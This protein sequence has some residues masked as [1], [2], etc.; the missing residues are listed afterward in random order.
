[1]EVLNNTQQQHLL[2]NSPQSIMRTKFGISFHSWGIVEGHHFTPKKLMSNSREQ[3]SGLQGWSHCTLPVLVRL[4]SVPDQ[5]QWAPLW[6][7]NFRLGDSQR[8]WG[9]S[10]NEAHEGS[11]CAGPDQPN[12]K[13][14]FF[15]S[16]MSPLRCSLECSMLGKLDRFHLTDVFFDIMQNDTG[17]IVNVSA[18]GCPHCRVLSEKDSPELKRLQFLL[19]HFA[20]YQEIHPWDENGQVLLTWT[21]VFC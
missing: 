8:T 4:G 20:L 12:T 10:R 18:L 11:R 2:M 3:Q 9:S 19:Y 15:V 13:V 17:D 7:S 1:M 16:A 5:H 14:F 21:K 6:V